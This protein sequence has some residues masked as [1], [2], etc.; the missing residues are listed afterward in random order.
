MYLALR[1]GPAEGSKWYERFAAWIIE[2]RLQTKW[3]HAGIVIGDTL[4]HAS[5]KGGLQAVPF[6]KTD[7]WTIY[8]CG[9]QHDTRVIKQF[10]ER[11]EK[12]G[13]K[14]RYDWFSLLAF[15]PAKYLGK[16]F[17]SPLRYNKWLYCYEWCF[18]VLTQKKV[19]QEV[20]PED[21]LQIY[22][23]KYQQNSGELNAE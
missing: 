23:E 14:V 8:D 19:T 17:K 15:T 12:A 2:A 1:A 7:I 22:I 21:L 9:K 18:E 16:L 11:L 3:P 6:L 5:A 20:T 4:Y 10:N 13:G